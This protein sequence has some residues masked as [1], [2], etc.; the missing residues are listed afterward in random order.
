MV[1]NAI[2]A[3]SQF[4]QSRSTSRHPFP[5]R[6]TLKALG[7]KELASLLSTPGLQIS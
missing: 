3:L 1:L 5:R 6:S 2:L 4:L 7:D